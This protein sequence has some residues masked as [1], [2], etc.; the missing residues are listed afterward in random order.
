MQAVIVILLIIRH[1]MTIIDFYYQEIILL[2]II[3]TILQYN[4]Y[5]IKYCGRKTADNLYLVMQM[6]ILLENINVLFV[7]LKSEKSKQNTKSEIN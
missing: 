1:I 2:W 7:Y 6:M 3:Y 5:N 4:K